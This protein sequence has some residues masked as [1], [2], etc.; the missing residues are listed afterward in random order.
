M[1]VPFERAVE[2]H[3]FD[4]LAITLAHAAAVTS[5]ARH[6]RDPFDR[7][8][9]AQALTEGATLVSHDRRLEPYGVPVLW[10]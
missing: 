9:V 3:G 1:E 2:V 4:K 10:A 8:L 6:H 7:M 5:L